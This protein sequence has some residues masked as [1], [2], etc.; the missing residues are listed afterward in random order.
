M[1][2]VVMVMLGWAREGRGEA[3]NDL[4]VLDLNLDSGEKSRTLEAA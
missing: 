3:S 2:A 1:S 4:S